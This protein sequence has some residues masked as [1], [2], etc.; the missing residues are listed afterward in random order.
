M[1]YMR[2]RSTTPNIS[3]FS[4]CELIKLNFSFVWS[5]WP[6]KRYAHTHTHAH[7]HIYIRIQ[8]KWERKK[9]NLARWTKH[10]S[11]AYAYHLPFTNIYTSWAD[12]KS[13]PKYEIYWGR[14]EMINDKI[15]WDVSSKNRGRRT[16]SA[17]IAMKK[18]NSRR[19]K[20]IVFVSVNDIE[21]YIKLNLTQDTIYCWKWPLSAWQYIYIYTL[22]IVSY[23]LN[24][25]KIDV[26]IFPITIFFCFSSIFFTAVSLI[27]IRL[28]KLNSQHVFISFDWLQLLHIYLYFIAFIFI[29]F[30][31]H[32]IIQSFHK[33]WIRLSVCV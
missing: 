3:T 1:H 26:N 28:F 11:Y 7:A 5:A 30:L 13:Q 31:Y 27:G 25:V 8:W 19:K 12:V 17:P 20:H 33:S 18:L 21:E 4:H 6:P 16:E 32:E 29:I 2:K 14:N 10:T 9:K 24:C 23:T 15:H 22:R